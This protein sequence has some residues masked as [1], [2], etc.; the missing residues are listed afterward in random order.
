MFSIQMWKCFQNAKNNSASFRAFM[1]DVN[2]FSFHECEIMWRHITSDCS[3]A[4]FWLECGSLVLR[5]FEC[6]DLHLHNVHELVGFSKNL[7]IDS[8][9]G[10]HNYL[11]VSSKIYFNKK[12]GKTF[13]KI[14]LKFSNFCEI[15]THYFV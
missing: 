5:A 8:I 15:R 14:I 7:Q 3:V 13:G 10:L 11:V 1:V 4:N 2:D 6:Q 9:V 12:K